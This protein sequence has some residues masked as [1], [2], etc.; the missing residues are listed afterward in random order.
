MLSTA[1]SSDSESINDLSVSD[2]NIGNYIVCDKT[3]QLKLNINQTD[4]LRLNDPPMT[5][6]KKQ[7]FSKTYSPM[8][9]GNYIA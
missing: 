1:K 9:T 8:K 6:T 4:L 7:N 5:P 2:I 3:L